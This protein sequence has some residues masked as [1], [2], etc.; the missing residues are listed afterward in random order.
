MQFTW[1][2]QSLIQI[3]A[4]LDCHIKKIIIICSIQYII[5]ENIQIAYLFGPLHC[6]GN[7]S[8]ASSFPL[9]NCGLC[10][11]PPPLRISDDLPLGLYGYFL[12]LQNFDQQSTKILPRK[13][14]FLLQRAEV[15]KLNSVLKHVCC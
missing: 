12:K 1:K 6:S 10:P 4:L 13:A 9:K 5:P 3:V 15:L 14:M 8:L 2:I 11:P 7:S